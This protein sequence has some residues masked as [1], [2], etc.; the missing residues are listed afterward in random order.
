ASIN[1]YTGGTFIK[2]GTLN[3]TTA[4]FGTGNI[5]NDAALIVAQDTDGTLSNA[6]SGTGF[7]TKDGT[8][9][10]SLAS[11]NSYTGGTF[12]KAGTLNV[13]GS[14]ADSDV[15]VENGASLRGTGTVG[16]VDVR[17]GGVLDTAANGVNSIL[18][19]NGN[20]TLQQ[21]ANYLAAVGENG[22]FTQT[23]VSG[24]ADLNDSS[25]T[26]ETIGHPVL[27]ANSSYQILLAAN[28]INGVFGK[29]KTN[30]EFAN[31]YYFLS[32]FLS[33]TS[34][35]VSLN[36]ER[37][38][39]S[40]A[41]VAT[42]RNQYGV[43]TALENMNS[44]N[45]LI[46]AVNQMDEKQARHAYNALSGEIHASVRTTML[47]NSFYIRNT[48]LDRL[49]S[50]DCTNGIS[51]STIKTASSGNRDGSSA[52][53]DSGVTA[54][55]TAYGS[56]GHNGGGGNA[57]GLHHEL[58]GFVMGADTQAFGTWRIGGLVS[59]GHST[60]SSNAVQSSG[61]SNDVS[62]GGYVG[63]HW[64]HIQFRT[65]AFY[66]WDMLGVNRTASL[67]ELNSRLSSHYLG[68]TAQ[69][70]GELAYQFRLGQT[71]QVE[72]F[73]HVAYVNAHTNAFN[74]HG[75]GAAALDGKGMDTGTTYSTFGMRSSSI[76]HIG[77]ALL[78]PTASL[79][80]RHSYG[81]LTPT[82]YERF[83]TGSS[84][85]EAA[86][87]LL[88]QNAAVINAG[89]GVRLS[90]RLDINISY[91]GQYGSQYTNSGVRGKFVCNF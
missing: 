41:S 30:L 56:W 37:N 81:I 31:S 51:Y 74:E 58:D 84:N 44:D 47:E 91:V 68:G 6:I 33:Y 60:F 24:K 26:L 12:I 63:T 78:M 79:G 39:R 14:I 38:A 5:V 66:S 46:G 4:S 48:A 21:G 23:R 76:F 22:S 83:A 28:G 55:G 64:G 54:W 82:I 61:H 43:G 77:N 2:A 9:T 42:T 35:S 34:D 57:S 18:H 75:S 40:Y 49:I 8:G 80:Y 72:P 25:I 19:I 15:V 67:R 7:L 62:V 90:D 52:C 69:T 88:A 16:S 29:E 1:S 53:G 45:A 87:A 73:A 50:A 70:F 20:L 85:F 17:D 3:G 36:V 71:T 10:V 59:Y 27:K 86:G 65:G 11:I 13:T 89:T 32:P